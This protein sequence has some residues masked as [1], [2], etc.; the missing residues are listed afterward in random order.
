M[1]QELC[2]AAGP[3]YPTECLNRNLTI[4]RLMPDV[5]RGDREECSRRRNTREEDKRQTTGP[6]FKQIDSNPYPQPIYPY[7]LNSPTKHTQ[8][9]SPASARE[10]QP[11]RT[12]RWASDGDSPRKG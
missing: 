8:T 2:H 12:G 7:F 1:C 10:K 5:L 3:D 11:N 6:Q 9:P 4:T